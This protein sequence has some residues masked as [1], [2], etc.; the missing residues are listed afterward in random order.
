MNLG[1]KIA[2]SIGTAQI[3]SRNR[4]DSTDIKYY[5]SCGNC[6]EDKSAVLVIKGLDENLENLNFSQNKLGLKS[7]LSLSERLKNNSFSKLLILNLYNNN[8]NDDAI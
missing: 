2:E 7:I 5:N 3:S 8:L 1:S 4:S 6:I